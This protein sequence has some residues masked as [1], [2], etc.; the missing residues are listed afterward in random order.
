MET[1]LYVGN[2][3]YDTSDADLRTLFGEA[4]TVE[5]VDVIKDR[6]SGRPKGFAF[7]TMG[8]QAEAEKAISMFNGKIVNDRPLTVNLARPREE[9]SGGGG[10]RFQSGTTH[11]SRGGS[12]KRY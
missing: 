4:G 11:R 2:M 12:N 5:T 6:D 7:I 10:G 1:K 9:R 8:T 3:S